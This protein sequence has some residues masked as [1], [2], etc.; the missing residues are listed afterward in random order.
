MLCGKNAPDD[1]DFYN[2]HL[3]GKNAKGT[4]NNAR[5]IISSSTREIGELQKIK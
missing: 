2:F 5:I 1:E 4:G 3:M